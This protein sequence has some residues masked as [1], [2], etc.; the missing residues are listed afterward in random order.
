MLTQIFIAF[1]VMKMAEEPIKFVFQDY[2]AAQDV[3][4][5]VLEGNANPKGDGWDL[6]QGMEQLLKRFPGLIVATQDDMGPLGRMDSYALG[7]AREKASALFKGLRNLE[8]IDKRIRERQRKFVILHLTMVN[9]AVARDREEGQVQDEE[10]LAWDAWMSDYN[11]V[12]ENRKDSDLSVSPEERNRKELVALFPDYKWE[13]QGD[14]PFLLPP[15]EEDLGKGRGEW[16][17]KLIFVK[18]LWWYFEGLEWS[19]G[20]FVTWVELAMDFEMATGLTIAGSLGTKFSPCESLQQKALSLNAMTKRLTHLMQHP[21]FPGLPCKGHLLGCKK[22]Q[23]KPGI[24]AKVSFRKPEVSLIIAKVVQG[25]VGQ[26][27]DPGSAKLHLDLGR[28]LWHYDFHNEV[29]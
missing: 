19:Q 14:T 18:A 9:V 3:R 5:L 8:D 7:E 24:G 17:F 21:V 2:S 25:F 13:R 1:Q 6:L 16:T 29:H 10:D 4:R 27:G 26:K 15:I 20:G 28:P 11:A 12:L 23:P 22:F